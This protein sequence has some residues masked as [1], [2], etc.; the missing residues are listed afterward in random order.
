MKCNS[1]FCTVGGRP[2][3]NKTIAKHLVVHKTTGNFYKILKS[4]EYVY[5][6]IGS[7]LTPILNVTSKKHQSTSFTVE[8]NIKKAFQVLDR[9]KLPR[10]KI[11]KDCRE[12]TTNF[13][14]EGLYKIWCLGNRHLKFEKHIRIVTEVI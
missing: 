13:E 7:M 5:G 2:R 9:L 12:N 8:I 1:F 10:V 4:Q 11:A 3:L 14:K 6:N